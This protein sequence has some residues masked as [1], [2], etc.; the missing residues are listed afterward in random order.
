VG[1][2]YWIRPVVIFIVGSMPDVMASRTNP[3]NVSLFIIGYDF[4]R[5]VVPIGLFSFKASKNWEPSSTTVSESSPFARFTFL[6][7]E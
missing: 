4:I 6:K 5:A 1:S 7:R 2:K 3:M